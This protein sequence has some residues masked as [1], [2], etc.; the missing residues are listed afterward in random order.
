MRNDDDDVRFVLNYMD[1]PLHTDTFI[2]ILSQP[3]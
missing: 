1:I 3:V 2:L